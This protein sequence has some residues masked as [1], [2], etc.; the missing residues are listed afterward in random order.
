M[1]V[2]QRRIPEYLRDHLIRQP[3]VN[4]GRSLTK[5]HS[6]ALPAASTSQ[7][8]HEELKNPERHFSYFA[9]N[10]RENVAADL[11]PDME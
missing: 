3:S 11:E 2:Q 4:S 9:T 10:L 5:V 7:N 1:Y 8:L 6:F